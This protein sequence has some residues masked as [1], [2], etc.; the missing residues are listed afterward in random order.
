MRPPPHRLYVVGALLWPAL[1]ACTQTVPV[2]TVPPA[3]EMRLLVKA[4]V[5]TD[6]LAS[7]ALAQRAAQI[8]KQPVRYLSANG[9]GWHVLLLGC[10]DSAQCD[11]GLQRLRGQTAEFQSVEPD[12]RKQHGPDSRTPA[13]SR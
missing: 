10:A 5:N 7:D 1:Q 9:A 11:A 3:V 8:A 12:G 13:T 6:G 4:G 2:A